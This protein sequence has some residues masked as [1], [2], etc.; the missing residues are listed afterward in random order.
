MKR[1]FYIST[2]FILLV[3]ITACNQQ[4]DIDMSEALGKSQET[5]RELDEIETTAASFNGESDVKFRLMVER[6]PTEEEAIILFNKILD[7][8]AQYSNHSEVWNY[9]NGYFDIK[10]YDSGVIYEATKLIGEDLHIL[11]K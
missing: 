1:L 3:L 2:A 4:L 5:L 6:H 9:Y 10:S 7:S 11:S 8:I